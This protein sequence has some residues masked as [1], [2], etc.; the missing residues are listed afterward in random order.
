M[1]RTILTSTLLTF[2]ILLASCTASQIQPTP[3]MSEVEVPVL[4]S[5]PQANMPNPASVYCEEQGNRSE[6]RTTADGSQSGACIFPDGSEC[7]E[8]AYFRGECRPAAQSSVSTEI[9]T[10]RPIDPADYQ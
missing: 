2:F 6:I 9:P 10:A 4:T 1:K 7:D 5:S 3:T 8:W